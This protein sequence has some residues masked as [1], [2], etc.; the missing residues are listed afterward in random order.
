MVKLTTANSGED[1]KQ[2]EFS[3]KADGNAYLA[4]SNKTLTI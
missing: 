4:V 1:V 2:L 3:F